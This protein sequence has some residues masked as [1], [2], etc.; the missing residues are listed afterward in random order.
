MCCT[1]VLAGACNLPSFP[2]LWNQHFA[3]MAQVTARSLE[4][5]EDDVSELRLRLKHKLYPPRVTVRVT[6]SDATQNSHEV[7]TVTGARFPDK[8][9]QKFSMQVPLNLPSR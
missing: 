6:A 8:S 1:V 4:L 3:F 7:F 9:R 5:W 2:L